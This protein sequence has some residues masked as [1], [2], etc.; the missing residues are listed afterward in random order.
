MNCDGIIIIP[1]GDIHRSIYFT[2]PV[3]FVLKKVVIYH[4]GLYEYDDKY[5]ISINTKTNSIT[6]LSGNDITDGSVISIYNKVLFLQSKLKI[7]HGTFKE[8]LPEQKMAVRFLTGKEKV[9][10]IV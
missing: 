3:K 7:N 5:T 10:E 2:D 9:L 1:A 4:D 6:A 8:E